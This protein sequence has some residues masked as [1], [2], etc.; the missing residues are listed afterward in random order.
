MYGTTIRGTK[1]Y[2]RSL[3]YGLYGAWGLMR[4]ELSG[5]GRVWGFDLGLGYWAVVLIADCE[6]SVLHPDA[7]YS[8]NRPCCL[9]VRVC[10]L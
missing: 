9:W 1:G 6:H 10:E 8:M 4:L 2:T 3:D 7:W 5:K